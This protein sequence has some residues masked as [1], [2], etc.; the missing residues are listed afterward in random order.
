MYEEID[1]SSYGK[2]N[3]VIGFVLIVLVAVF[4]WQFFF[5][6]NEVNMD[7]DPGYG[8]LVAFTPFIFYSVGSVLG[9]FRKRSTTINV[10]HLEFEEQTR[11]L[12][13]FGQ[14]Y[15]EGD[16]ETGDLGGHPVYICGWTL[17]LIAS[18]LILY[19]IMSFIDTFGYT[20]GVSILLTLGAV[21]YFVSI[22]F[23][24]KGTP[25]SSNL[26]RNPLH[27]R[28]TKYFTRE[29]VG[30]YLKNCDIVSSVIMRYRIAQ[31]HSL[32]A[33]DDVR[34]ILVTSTAPPLEVEVT[35][36]KMETIGPEYTFYLSESIEERGEETIIVDDKDIILTKGESDMRSYVRVRYDMNRI[37]AKWALQT[38]RELCF[39]LNVLLDEVKKYVD[40]R[41]II[42]DKTRKIEKSYE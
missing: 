26:V 24:F 18:V 27:H 41:E 3:P 5:V 21:L 13:D 6:S 15:Y 35:I 12:D 11:E 31:G 20:F 9:F 37:R 38:E 23:A 14:V 32:K 7:I 8:I 34:L 4:S 25:I 16:D 33:V 36:P 30:K 39:L 22:F 42:E 29:Y 10:G 28:I 40:F 2:W 17:V 19:A 1:T